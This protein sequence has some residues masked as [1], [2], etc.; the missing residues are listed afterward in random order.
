MLNKEL[1]ILKVKKR[2]REAPGLVIENNFSTSASQTSE[3]SN[4]ELCQ[5]D[6]LNINIK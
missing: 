1:M 2:N 6:G 3:R 5:K 4:P